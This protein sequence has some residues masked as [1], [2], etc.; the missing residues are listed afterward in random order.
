MWLRVASVLLA[1]RPRSYKSYREEV[2]IPLRRISV[3][4]GKNNSGKTAA[5][6]LPLLMLSAL[7]RRRGRGEPLPLIVRG[8]EYGASVSEL[9]Y[10]QSAHSGFSVG[11]VVNL[12]TLDAEVDI[13]LGFQLRQTLAE[14]LKA[15]V[16]EFEATPLLPAVRWNR[17][18]GDREITYADDRVSGFDG[19]LPRYRDDDYEVRAEGLERAAQAAL[20]NFVHLT[21][22]RTPL[23]AVYE[24]KTKE[25]AFDP[26]GADVPYL[27]RDSDELL[28][29]V[30]EW[31]VKELGT[32]IDIERDATAFRLVSVGSSGGPHLLARAGQGIQQVLPVVAHLRSMATESGTEVAVVEEPELNLHPAAHGALA[33]LTV[34]AVESAPGRQALIETHSENYVLRLRYHVATGRLSPDAV[35]LLWFQQ[36]EGAT[37]VRE[38]DIGQDGSVSEWPQ[39]VFYED[40]A[41]ARAISRAVDA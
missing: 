41:E 39:G 10:G 12:P 3:L 27:L 15:F 7:S 23:Q 6:R 22:L 2:E 28:D 16:A 20:D 40:L 17:D 37:T 25:G 18:L 35:N 11:G 8:L 1:L 38:I 29:S 5:A 30:S 24:H 33:D 26:T 31:Y 32:R 4:L 21:S 19:V 36:E 9:V 34:E 14:G 13:T